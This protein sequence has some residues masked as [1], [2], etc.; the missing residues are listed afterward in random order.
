M[1]K[2]AG[3]AR[4]AAWSPAWPH[5]ACLCARR[6]ACP[7]LGRALQQT[8]RAR[9]ARRCSSLFASVWWRAR[10]R[11]AAH[12]RNASPTRGWGCVAMAAG[13][14][15]APQP[16][17]EEHGQNAT[18]HESPSCCCGCR[19]GCA[20]HSGRCHGCCSTTRRAQASRRPD[21]LLPTGAVMVAVPGA[22]VARFARGGGRLPRTPSR[23]PRNRSPEPRV[24]GGRGYET[25][26]E[27]N[28]TRKPKPPLR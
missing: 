2:G 16:E 20:R 18:P 23:G 10:R 13:Q 27:R 7:A 26:A 6:P 24:A 8:L 11:G 5:P 15:G 19:G 25:G 28:T 4:R 21:R 3:R 9:P 22:K 17:P 12:C 14:P 1:E